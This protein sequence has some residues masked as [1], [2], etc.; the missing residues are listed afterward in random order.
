MF[1][2]HFYGPQVHLLDS[3]FLNGIL[4]KLCSPQTYQPEINRL[5]HLLY[6]HLISTVIDQEF[7]HETVETEKQETI[8]E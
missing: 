6:T 2:K 4:A 1:Q 7:E 8:D 3:P 5:V